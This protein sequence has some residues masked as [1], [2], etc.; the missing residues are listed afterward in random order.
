M[1]IL[2]VK[3][4]YSRLGVHTETKNTAVYMLRATITY[5]DSP[6]PKKLY[7]K[8][9]QGFLNTKKMYEGCIICQTFFVLDVNG[10]HNIYDADGKYQT[11]L[12]KSDVGP[13]VDVTENYFFCLLG[14]TIT[15]YDVNGKSI[16]SQELTP[17]ELADY[18][19]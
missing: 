2:D 19:K 15:G 12:L 16:G 9:P 1:N 14:K 11:S 13:C 3:I 18:T 4:N 8:L 10:S 6:K 5:E 7:I 17:E